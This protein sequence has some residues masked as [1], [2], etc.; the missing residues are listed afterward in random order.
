MAT[1]N[2]FITMVVSTAER[3]IPE[4][5]YAGWRETESP[6]AESGHKSEEDFQTFLG[7]M[8]VEIL[9]ED[10]DPQKVRELVAEGRI[11]FRRSTATEDFESGTDG[12]FFNPLTGKMVPED[13]TISTDPD[14]HTE[15]REREREG[16]PRFLPLNKR[17]LE[18]AARGSQRD[19]DKVWRSVNVLLLRDALDQA[20][21]GEVRIPE[22]KL[23]GIERRLAELQYRT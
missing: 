5:V 11:A 3:G 15:K 4:E 14:V 10:P 17:E 21:S 22:A 8:G 19:Q 2:K 12:Y 13:M 23:A 16:G 6:Y 7:K 18:L 9:K 1:P 20:R